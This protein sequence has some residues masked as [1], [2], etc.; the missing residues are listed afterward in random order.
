[1]SERTA[2]DTPLVNVR[3]R[4]ALVRSGSWSYI[5]DR[6][7]LALGAQ[8]NRRHAVY[9]DR[10]YFDAARFFKLFLLGVLCGMTLLPLSPWI[11][12]LARPADS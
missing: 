6:T 12:R 11:A 5:V 1:M 4:S 8:I 10:R 7:R 2:R 9:E 3:A